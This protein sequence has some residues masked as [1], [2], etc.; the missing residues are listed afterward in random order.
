MAQQLVDWLVGLGFNGIS[1]RL[2]KIGR[3][4]K[5]RSE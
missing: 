5:E 3:K 4:R 1:G 2:V